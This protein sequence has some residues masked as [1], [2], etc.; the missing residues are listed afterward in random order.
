M[1]AINT[2]DPS[3]PFASRPAAF[4]VMIGFLYSGLFLS[5]SATVT[6][7]IITEMFSE[8]P[9]SAARRKANPEKSDA[10]HDRGYISEDL[11][12]LLRRYGM[13]R[14]LRTVQWHCKSYFLIGLSPPPRCWSFEH[15]A[16]LRAELVLHLFLHF[17]HRVLLLHLWHHAVR[18]E[19]LDLRYN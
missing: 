18:F 14:G 10:L 8:L 12:A 7:L 9:L 16:I 3:E 15:Q 1:K 5:I 4:D 6:P 19:H 13:R 11:P 2:T 17:T